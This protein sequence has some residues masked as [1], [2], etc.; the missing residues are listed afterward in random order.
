VNDQ[1]KIIKPVEAVAE[2]A[3]GRSLLVRNGPPSLSR[4]CGETT[5]SYTGV[6]L[7]SKLAIVGSYSSPSAVNSASIL[8]S[9]LGSTVF[10]RLPISLW[11][12]VSVDAASS[13]VPV[14]PSLNL[15]NSA[16]RLRTFALSSRWC[17]LLSVVQQQCDWV[18]GH[19]LRQFE[20]L[21]GNNILNGEFTLP[22]APQLRCRRFR[23][24]VVG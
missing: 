23:V 15:M 10:L 9:S 16:N 19:S 18:R 24:Q 8:M 22:G 5:S 7:V 6:V 14:G 1:N 17:T 21:Q 4:H 12:R 11:I 2:A 13:I 3:E 20:V